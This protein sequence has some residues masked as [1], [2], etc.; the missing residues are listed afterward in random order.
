M[1]L[2]PILAIKSFVAYPIKIGNISIKP[3]NIKILLL[4]QD[5]F[6]EE[7]FLQADNVNKKLQLIYIFCNEDNPGLKYLAWAD[8]Q[9]INLKLCYLACMK[10]LTDCFQ[11]IFPED[12]SSKKIKQEDNTGQGFTASMLYFGMNT[13]HL[14]WNDCMQ[15]P[16]AGLYILLLE[17]IR[18]NVPKKDIKFVDLKTREKIDQ[19]KSQQQQHSFSPYLVVNRLPILK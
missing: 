2:D 18:Q 8:S 5:V 6:G 14:S 1:K 10:Q 11:L 16:L 17:H 9:Q 4:I 12:S 3:L 13:L 19:I 7:D 15:T